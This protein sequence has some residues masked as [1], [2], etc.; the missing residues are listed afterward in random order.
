MNLWTYVPGKLDGF[1]T[2]HDAHLQKNTSLFRV[3]K[4]E[5]CEERI[6]PA[7]VQ[8]NMAKVDPDHDTVLSSGVPI[9]KP[10]D[11]SW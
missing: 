8:K 3:Q 6:R 11:V 1:P 2:H 5:A 7:L 4:K 10:V 9:S